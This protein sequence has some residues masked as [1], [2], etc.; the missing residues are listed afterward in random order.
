M[1]RVRLTDAEN[2]AETLVVAESAREREHEA[3]AKT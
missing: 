2:S 3:Q 1:L